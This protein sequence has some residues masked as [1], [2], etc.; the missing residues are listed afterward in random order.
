MSPRSLSPLLALLLLTAC[1]DALNDV[2]LHDAALQDAALHD[3]ALNDAAQLDTGKPDAFVAPFSPAVCGAKAYSWLPPGSLGKVLSS[4]R[5]ATFSLPKAAL[6]TL[7]KL[8]DFKDVVKV[9]YDVEVYLFRYE[10]QD[11][12]KKVEATGAMAFPK[13]EAGKTM[14]PPSVLW[15]HGTS[16]FSDKCAPTRKITEAAAPAALM[17]AQGYIGIAP[18]FIGMTGFG[19]ASTT[20]HPYVVAEPTA[21]ASLD[22][23]RAAE[24]IV[25]KESAQISPS[26]KLVVWGPS[27]GGHATLSTTLY[28]PYYLPS[29]QVV[30]AMPLIAPADL[31]A[32][33]KAA[34]SSWS[35]ST[36]ILAGIF[37]AQARWYGHEA[38]LG[39]VFVSPW[40]K[41]LI[42]LMDS[43]CSVNEKKYNLTKVTDLYKQS[44]IDAV[45]KG[46]YS[47]HKT[48]SCMADENSLTATSVKAKALPPILFVVGENDELVDAASQRAS[49]D[50][51]CKAGY[52]MEYLEC[53]GANHVNG[54]LWSLPEQFSWL[55]DR[56]AGK[57]LTSPCK[58][59]PAVCCKGTDKGKCK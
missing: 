27:Q 7:L 18:D 55:E 35:G 37:T 19:A 15:L 16:G 56:L 54:A 58:R 20:F 47:K 49:F 39:E 28:A 46:D 11:R 38:R 2:A 22:A 52:K 43:V 24:A 40:D 3:A 5:N 42:T 59:P 13:L 10:T 9:K 14:T 53:K 57:A 50:A 21:I 29:H 48:W 30:A 4:Q 36:V 51:L 32:Q 6:E 23:V 41:Q 34:L 33:G 17:A 44:F 8:T 25:E 26:K 31:K 45:T 1:S 12:G